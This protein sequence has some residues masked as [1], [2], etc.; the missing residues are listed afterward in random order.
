MALRQVTNNQDFASL[1]VNFTGQ[2]AQGRTMCAPSGA[3][4]LH[5]RFVNRGIFAA[6]DPYSTEQPGMFAI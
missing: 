5:G 4:P 6:F 2:C 1:V 3:G